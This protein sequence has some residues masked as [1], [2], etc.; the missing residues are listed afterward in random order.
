MKKIFKSIF[1]YSY[2]SAFLNLVTPLILFPI[3]SNALGP[4]GLGMYAWLE[5]FTKYFCVLGSIGIPL[6]GVR[7]VAQK[8]D[9]KKSFT[10]L[11]T[12]N[13][14]TTFISIS[15]YLIIVNIFY[16]SKELY[17]LILISPLIVFNSINFDWYFHGL[18]NFKH[19]AK[20]IF[21]SRIIYLVLIINLVKSINDIDKYIV[22]NIIY[23][24]LIITLSINKLKFDKKINLSGV[25][26]HFK[27]SLTLGLSQFSILI[28]VFSDIF[29][30]GI[31][32]SKIDIG[33]YSFGTKF[34]YIGTILIGVLAAT[35]LPKLSSIVNEKLIFD[36]LFKEIFEIVFSLGLIISLII[37]FSSNTLIH[38]FGN[39]LFSKSLLVIKICSILP[40]I[41]GL[42][43]VIGKLYFISNKKD[44]MFSKL[45][46][47]GM[48]LNLF[49]NFIFIPK[50]SYFGAF[51]TTVF[52]EITLLLLFLYFSGLSK[53]IFSK[54]EKISNLFFFLSLFL[55]SF[56]LI[57]INDFFQNYHILK[58]IINILSFFIIFIIYK[59]THLQ[60]ILQYENNNR[61][62]YS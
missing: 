38:V 62:S 15:I 35:F 40:L 13:L 51:S 60:K 44:G 7:L 24:I 47:F 23:S 22:I 12:L 14:F 21:F 33:L 6:Y 10:E 56:F 9:I 1:F 28:Y 26:R 32:S 52:T 4:E 43:E 34:S 46:I 54:K 17:F 41:I 19:I 48:F 58:L 30:L 53:L 16:E 50:F 20:K 2:L 55:T 37:Y 36:K 39:D 29:I 5:N 3:I 42:N 25:L 49:L 11:F 31:Y 18:Q 61:G 8:E 59:K 45:L 27:P 57:Y